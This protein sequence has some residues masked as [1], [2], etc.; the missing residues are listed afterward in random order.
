MLKK[1]LCVLIISAISILLCSCS[2]NT[3]DKDDTSGS[4]SQTTSSISSD[5]AP[6][7]SDSS[8]SESSE[9]SQPEKAPTLLFMGHASIR[10][11]TPEDKVIYIDPFQGDGYDLTA[12]L[13]LVTHGH[14]DHSAMDKIEKRSDDCVTITH[15]EAL[16]DG[17]HKTFELGY[18]TVEAVEAGNNKNH[19][20]NECVGY[21]LTFS[22]GKSVYISGDTSTTEQ[23]SKLA[24]K[25]IDY[26]FFCCDGNF[27]MDVEEALRCAEMVGAKHNIPYHYDSGKLSDSDIAEQFNADN[28]L[29]I[30]PGEELLVE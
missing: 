30:T 19:D 4:S 3:D 24:E 13:I 2:A 16:V 9:T 11:V 7:N 15:K 25:E 23:M 14:G 1:L 22:N 6:E 21:V 17:E 18:V 12:D 28:R 29:I 8:T 27:N 20:I 10:I 26:A 5:T